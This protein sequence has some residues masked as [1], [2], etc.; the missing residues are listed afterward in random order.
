MMILMWI[1]SLFKFFDDEDY[2]TEAIEQ[3]LEDLNGNIP[4]NINDKQII[5]KLTNFIATNK[6]F[7][8]YTM[9]IYI[10]L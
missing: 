5:Q 10:C 3:D 9:Q 2:E 8:I 7:D 6:G 1:D 4:C